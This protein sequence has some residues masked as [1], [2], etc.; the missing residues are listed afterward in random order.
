MMRHHINPASSVVVESYLMLGLERRLRRYE[1]ICDVM[2]SWDKDHENSLLILSCPASMSDHDLDIDAVPNS[3]D[4]PPGFTLHLHH[5]SRPG[6]W[7]KRWITLLE[8]GQMFASKTAGSLPDDPTTVKLCQI[9]EFDIYTPKEAEVRQSV[10]PPKKFCYAIKSQ[11]KSNMFPDEDNFVH[12]FSTDDEE[13]A[14]QFYE[15]IHGWRSWYL[16][17][18]KVALDR[19]LNAPA[20]QI[21]FDSNNGS[22]TSGEEIKSDSEPSSATSSFRVGSFQPLIDMDNISKLAEE[23]RKLQPPELEPVPSPKV[24]DRHA[25]PPMP[26]FPPPSTP[27]PSKTNKL[28]V[29][30]ALRRAE[31]DKNAGS[32]P[33]QMY[34][35]SPP[36]RAN[37]K[38]ETLTSSAP[39]NSPPANSLALEFDAFNFEVPEE[40]PE[41]KSWFPSAAE[42]TAKLRKEAPPPPIRRPATADPAV[43]GSQRRTNP[44][45]SIKTDFLE[46]PRPFEN[47]G[48]QPNRGTPGTPFIYKLPGT[49]MMPQPPKGR[50]M[51]RS[52]SSTVGQ[53]SPTNGM[54][55]RSRST[56]GAPQGR[57]LMAEN[58]PPVPALPNRSMRRD[59]PMPP[60]TPAP[61]SVQPR[62]VPPQRG[63]DGRP[64][65]PFPARHIQ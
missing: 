53:A 36:S 26:D 7:N 30:P 65:N 17:S 50:P 46:P 23:A 56:A 13:I 10:K 39:T 42:H 44:Q 12:F 63:P 31:T 51:P 8:N 15:M 2:N 37:G 3:E 52:S 5:S 25:V 59:G 27:L 35:S 45:L 64:L 29:K 58:M 20:P 22:D 16:V 54:R 34:H 21:T 33:N 11:Q 55:P 61:L 47:Y 49:P 6:K 48:G 14:T 9:N 62:H 38:M 40:K 41:P 43:H 24:E 60:A 18:R 28:P 57:R 1:R 32:S 19:K 4:S